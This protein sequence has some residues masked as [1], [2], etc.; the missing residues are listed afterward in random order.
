VRQMRMGEE[1]GVVGVDQV[2][3]KGLKRAQRVEGDS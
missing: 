3:R 1:Q 2:E